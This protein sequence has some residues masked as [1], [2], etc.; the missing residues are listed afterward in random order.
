[1]NDKEKN[2]M[3]KIKGGKKEQKNIGI[4]KEEKDEMKFSP[5]SL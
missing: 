4:K 2:I 3:L 1:M 5:L